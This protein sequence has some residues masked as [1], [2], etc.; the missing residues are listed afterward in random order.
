MKK[1]HLNALGIAVSK[2]LSSRELLSLT[3]EELFNNETACKIAALKEICEELYGKSVSK[4]TTRITNSLDSATALAP[5]LRF[6]DHEECWIVTLNSM[7]EVIQKHC[8]GAGGLRACIIDIRR[9]VRTALI[10]NCAGV[11]LAHNHPSGNIFPSSADINETEKL[12]DALKLFDINLL[13]H[14]IITDEKFYSF[15]DEQESTIPSI[16]PESR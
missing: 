7:N 3:N 2:D 16:K 1:E 4:R 12:R 15:S 14:L 9:I 11:I 8:I 13:D 6:L 10:D 5:E